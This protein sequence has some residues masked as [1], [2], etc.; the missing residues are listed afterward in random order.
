MNKHEF[1]VSS[2]FAIALSIIISLIA[3]ITPSQKE[4]EI[5]EKCQLIK[6]DISTKT[7]YYRCADGVEYFL[8]RLPK[9]EKP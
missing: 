3:W 2:G 5:M 6:Q 9:Q 1:G 8:Y 4:V 7:S